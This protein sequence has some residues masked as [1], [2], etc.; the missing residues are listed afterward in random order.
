MPQRW[1]RVDVVF[2]TRTLWSVHIDEGRLM[3]TN[4]NRGER[5]SAG[6]IPGDGGGNDPLELVP[7]AHEKFAI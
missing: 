7:V 2:P 1:K 4:S 5:M 3:M 6:L